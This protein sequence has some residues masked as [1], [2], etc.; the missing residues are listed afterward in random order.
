[1]RVYLSAADRQINWFLDENALDRSLILNI[2]FQDG[3]VTPDIFFFISPQ[4][5]RHV[6]GTRR[7]SLLA[8]A[9]GE[10]LVA[11]AFR[12]EK[13]ASFA[14]ALEAI[15]QQ[16]IQGVRNDAAEVADRLD[17]AWEQGAS[18][19]LERWPR[20]SLGLAFDTVLR[21][22]LAGEEP[23]RLGADLSTLQN[24]LDEL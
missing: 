21:E 5:E 9:L 18:P 14:D 16:G 4:I 10:G 24:E 22:A 12:D 7:Q 11:P 23:P 8:A 15:R 2:F 6:L 1:M 3:I 17:I 20:A 13:V 19:T